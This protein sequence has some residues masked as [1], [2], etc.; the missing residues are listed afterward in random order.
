MS[1]P[2]IILTGLIYLWVAIDQYRQ[3]NVGLAVAYSGYA[4]SNIGLYLL[5][6]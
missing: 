3:G 5:A 2:L 1:G 6:K 4:Y